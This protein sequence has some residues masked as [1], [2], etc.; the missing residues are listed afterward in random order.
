MS[1]QRGHFEIGIVLPNYGSHT[2]VDGVMR[3]AE[4]AEE[5]GFD[6]VW[7]TEHLLVDEE[8]A[9]P[10]GMV[11][12]PLNCL[13]WLAGQL[14]HVKLGTSVVLLPLHDPVHL[15]KEA[16]TLQQ[17]SRGRLRL[18][19]GVGWHEPEFAFLGYGFSDR[20]RRTDEALRLMPALWEGRHEFSGEYCSFEGASFG[21]LPD[22]PPE[23]WIAGGS[24]RSLRRARELGDAWHPLAL[25]P[26][27]AGRAK[28]EWPEGCIVPRYE[29]ELIEGEKDS[30]ESSIGMAGTPAEVAARIGDLARSGAD[31]IVL[32][33][34]LEPEKAIR[35]LWRFAREV[36]PRLTEA[37]LRD[38][39]S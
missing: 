23:V 32:G 36:L 30:A 16:A 2:S 29:L 8:Y 10:Y 18:C 17:L 24:P 39:S 13:S 5:L 38:H 37:G 4:A 6:S 34:G 33:V 14:E 28:R 7:A 12:E 19:L 25:S 3:V 15:A 26:E 20:G 9:D 31:G 35:N 21:P 27:Q 1:E 11:L 22:T